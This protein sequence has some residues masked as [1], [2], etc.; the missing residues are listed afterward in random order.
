MKCDT[1]STTF[2]TIFENDTCNRY[3]CD[4]GRQVNPLFV[5]QHLQN[6]RDARGWRTKR[7]RLR[8]IESFYAVYLVSMYLNFRCD[9]DHYYERSSHYYYERS[10]VQVSTTSQIFGSFIRVSY[11]DGTSG[12]DNSLWSDLLLIRHIHIRR[13]YDMLNSQYHSSGISTQQS[14]RCVSA[15]CRQSQGA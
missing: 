2:D 5:Q 11:G 12:L 14:A 7:V 1:I 9:I 13:T 15:I 8:Y 10:A 3:D 4:R 6:Y